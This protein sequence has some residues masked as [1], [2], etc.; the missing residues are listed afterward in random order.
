MALDQTKPLKDRDICFSKILEHIS[1]DPK[2]AAVFSMA[3]ALHKAPQTAYL[4]AYVNTVKHRRLIRARPSVRFEDAPGHGL[5][6]KAFNYDSKTHGGKFPEKWVHDFLFE[7][8][9]YVLQ[10]LVRTGN[11]L[12]RLL[13]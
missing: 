8:N 6:I 11:A 1:Q 13:R 4:C 5:R 9:V 7:D 12:S 10:N 2:V 3:D